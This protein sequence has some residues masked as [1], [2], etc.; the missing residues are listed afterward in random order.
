MS[1]KARERA[2]K[3]A[4]WSLILLGAFS[5]LHVTWLTGVWFADLWS[6]IRSFPT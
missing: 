1:A 3:A 2:W 4:G 5:V 6:A